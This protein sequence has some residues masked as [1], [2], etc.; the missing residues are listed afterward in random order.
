MMGIPVKFKRLAAVFEEAAAKNRECESS[1]SEHSPESLT[2]LSDLVNSFLER[3]EGEAEE[4]DREREVESE[5]ENN[6]HADFELLKNDLES[7]LDSDEEDSITRNI[8]AEVEE[9]CLEIGNSSL[10]DFKRRLM[11]RLRLRGFDAG[12]CKSKWEKT[13]GCPS[14]DY[15]YIDAYVSGTR[16]IVEVFL[17][18]EFTIARPTSSYTSLLEVFPSIYVGK[19]GRFKK[20]VKLM[21]RAMRKSL[22]TNGLHLPPWRRL[23]YLQAKWFGSYKRTINEIPGRTVSDSDEGLSQKRLIGFVPVQV[24]VTNAGRI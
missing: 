4:N 5:L 1:G 15:E 9:A 14:G 22:K 23:A 11:A 24:I 20:V 10:P 8:H 6:C 19:V 16:F 12:L 13:G 21:C 2:D 17:A 7:L 3:E 18:G